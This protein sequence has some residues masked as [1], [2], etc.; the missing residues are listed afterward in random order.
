MNVSKSAV[1]PIR[2]EGLDIED[3][4]ESFTCQIKSFPSTYLGLPLH[5]RQLRR[6][7]IQPLIDKVTNRLPTWKGR[8]LNKAGRLRL[9]NTV[10]SSIP[11]YFLTVFAPKK[12]AV[13]RIDK[14]RRGFLWEGAESASGGHCLVNWQK[15]KRPKKLGGLGV[16]DLEPFSQALRMC[17]LWLQ[18]TDPDRPWARMPVICSEVD[19]QLFRASTCVTLGNGEWAKFWDSAWLEGRAPRDMA[20]NLY[21]LAWRKN[22][23]VQEDLQNGNWTRG[24]WRMSTVDEMAEMVILGNKIQMVQ[25]NDQQDVIRWRWTADGQYTAKSAYQAQL[26][27]SYCSFDSKALWGAKVEGKHWFFAWL[28]VQCKIL[29]ADKLVKRNWPCNEICQLC[30]QIHES[31]EHLIL[32]CVYAK[33]IWLQMSSESEGLLQVPL[34]DVSMEEWWNTSIQGRDRKLKQRIASLMIYTA[35]NIWRERNRRIFE[36]KTA[37]PARVVE[38]IKEEIHLRNQACGGEE[39]IL[40]P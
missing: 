5:Y 30:D 18:W 4:M 23:T 13:K 21:K 12:W 34:D 3:I 10:L 26:V 15:V 19:K 2:C 11:T 40:V 33:E 32:H 22:Q 14:I 7:D 9:M 16:L 37:L 29:T 6:V 1:Y 27:G 28:L 36:G 35:W 31:A 20:P 8:F 39:L 24:L 25:L 38:L 17:W